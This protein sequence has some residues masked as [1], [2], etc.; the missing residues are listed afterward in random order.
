MPDFLHSV[1]DY[2]TLPIRGA[3]RASTPE[4]QRGLLALVS[5]GTVVRPAHHS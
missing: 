5:D 3:G 1:S 4:E 2:N